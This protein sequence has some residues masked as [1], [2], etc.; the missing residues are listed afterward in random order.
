MKILS[1]NVLIAPSEKRDKIGSL[2]VVA[3]DEDQIVG[4]VIAVGPGRVTKDG[5]LIEMTV[6]VGD[7]VMLKAGS[8][9]RVSMEGKVYIVA[10]ETEIVGVME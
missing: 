5:L 6:K 8:G 7:S 1:N 9:H 2:F 4:D 3:N 10:P